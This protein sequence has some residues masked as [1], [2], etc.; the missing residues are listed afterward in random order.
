MTHFWSTRPGS[1]SSWYQYSTNISLGD[2]RSELYEQPVQSGPEHRTQGGMATSLVYASPTQRFRLWL[3]TSSSAEAQK[4]APTQSWDHSPSTRGAAGLIIL[5][6]EGLESKHSAQVSAL[7]TKWLHKNQHEHLSPKPS[8]SL[9][10][11]WL[12]LSFNS[13]WR[14]PCTLWHWQ[15]RLFRSHSPLNA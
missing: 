6:Q 13:M 9:Q 10:A 2:S 3:C 4:A 15:H 12:G 11:F 1:E 14:N 5:R 7:P 8:T